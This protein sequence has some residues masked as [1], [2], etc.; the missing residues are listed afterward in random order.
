[1][2]IRAT[3]VIDTMDDLVAATSEATARGA[4]LRQQQLENDDQRRLAF[5]SE[6]D[7][8]DPLASFSDAERQIILGPQPHHSQTQRDD[9]EVYEEL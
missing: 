6:H 9:D 5:A 8:N 4:T 2:I 1:L 7:V 3:I